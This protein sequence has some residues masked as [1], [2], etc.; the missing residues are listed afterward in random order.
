MLPSTSIAGP[1]S[2]QR[3][4]FHNS[5]NRGKNKQ[6]NWMKGNQ[7]GSGGNKGGGQFSSDIQP[8]NQFRD[9]REMQQNQGSFGQNVS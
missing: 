2:S 7:K 4:N 9:A 1:D 3:G 6:P 5:G 8:N